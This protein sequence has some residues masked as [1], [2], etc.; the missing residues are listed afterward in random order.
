VIRP[1][2]SAHVL[3]AA[4]GAAGALLA[5]SFGVHAANEPSATDTAA[6]Q[7]LRGETAQAVASYTTALSDAGLSNDRRATI[8]NDRGVAYMRGG[9]LKLAI[10]DFNK[11]AQLFPE[12]AA[13]YNNRGNLLVSLGLLKEAM[14][15]LDRA[16]LLA[17]GFAAAYNNRASALIK[18]GQI[19]DAI[20]DYTK[21]V[22]LNPASAVPLSGRGRAHLMLQRPHAASRDF[23]RAVTADARF[24]PGYRNRA[25][26]K[27]MTDAYDEAIE[28]LSRAIAF[29]VGNAEIYVVRGD[30]YLA[31]RNIVSAIKDFSQAIEL[32]PKLVAAYQSRGLAHGMAE[33]WDDAFAD[34][35]KAIELDPRAAVAFA[36]RAYVYKQTGQV[37]VGQKDVETAMKL[38][39]KRAEVYWAKAEIEEAQTQTDQAVADLRKALVIRPG[40]RDARDTLQRLGGDLVEDPGAVIAG[41]GVEPWKVIKRGNQYMAVSDIYPRLSVPL[42]ML[43]QG[44][45]KLLEWEEKLAPFRG[46]GVLRFSGGSLKT[47]AGQEDT[48]LL[49]LVDINEARVM[50][51]TPDRQGDKRSTWTWDEGKVTVAALDGGTEEFNV[52]PGR[53][54]GVAGALAPGSTRRVSGSDKNGTAWAPWNDPLAGGGAPGG[55][56]AAPKPQKSV[57]RKQ[58]PKTLFDLLFN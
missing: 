18:L 20:G 56:G 19:G 4:L 45:P 16:I 50:S 27:I 28:D 13:V 32:N 17:P 29:D 36:Y 1:R 58:K 9:Q 40:Y 3:V 35:N 8:L 38:D 52:R 26:A 25:E 14:K 48:E 11:A 49:A 33:A 34:L 39:D 2:A 55:A 51:I 10:E 53:D 30:A 44:E 23:T 57:Q 41:A 21:A 31:V 5:G 24:A 46:I 7:L 6:T 15:D 12:Y 54:R 42:E 43:G 37:G 47:T 22:Q